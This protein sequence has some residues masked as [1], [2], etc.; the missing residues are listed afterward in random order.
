IL[1]NRNTRHIGTTIISIG[2]GDKISSRRVDGDLRSC[3]SARP[4]VAGRTLSYRSAGVEVYG[5]DVAIEFGIAGLDIRL[6]ACNI[7]RNRN[8][9]G[10]ASR[11]E[12]L[13]ADMRV[14][15]R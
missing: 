5:S 7:L 4:Q 10:R 3:G 15:A 13:R 12:V 11:R 9:I 8:K 2:D 14:R 1:R 6:R